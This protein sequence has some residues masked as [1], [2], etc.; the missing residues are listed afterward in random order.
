MGV[1]SY[2][3]AASPTEAAACPA[4]ENAPHE[5]G[6]QSAWRR[7]QNLTPQGWRSCRKGELTAMPGIHGGPTYDELSHDT[8]DDEAAV[9]WM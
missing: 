7:R 2:H 3:S 4:H 1:A 9:G 8:D 5:H 6:R